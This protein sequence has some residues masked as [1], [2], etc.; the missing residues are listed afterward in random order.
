MQKGFLISFMIFLFVVSTTL[1]LVF[2]PKTHKPVAFENRNFKLELISQSAKVDIPKTEVNINIP[3]PEINIEPPKINVNAE[4]PKISV[5]AETPKINIKTADTPKAQ[6][7]PK[8]TNKS[9]TS[10]KTTNSVK[11]KTPA[12][13]NTKQTNPPKQTTEKKQ[14]TKEEKP[15]QQSVKTNNNPKAERKENNNVQEPTAP[16]PPA[17]VKPPVQTPKRELTQEEIEII[18]WNKWRS[19]LQNQLMRD[20]KISAPIGTRFLF[21]FTVDKYGTITNLKTWANNPS[22]T[23]L[24]VKVIKPI[25]LS[26]QGKPI[27]NF[28]ANS[29]RITTNVDGGF[30]M[31]YSS[32]YSKPSDYNDYERIKK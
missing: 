6:K 1:V 15:V 31:A 13:D 20:S 19:D 14:T 25:L 9:Q 24:A 21:S 26:Y 18:A 16:L 7:Q 11:P 30:T 5:N 12:A 3:A 23:P 4:I 2:K 22:Y 10:P 32:N 29:K 28:P 8:Q 27:L 17:T